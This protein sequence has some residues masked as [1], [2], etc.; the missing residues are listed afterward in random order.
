MKSWCSGYTFSKACETDACFR[1]KWKRAH[2]APSR[3]AQVHEWMSNSGKHGPA[4]LLR[5]SP[6]HPPPSLGILYTACLPMSPSLLLSA[7]SALR[8]FLI[9]LCPMVLWLF[10]ETPP[11]PHLPLREGDP[12]G[13]GPWSHLHFS[14]PGVQEALVELRQ[15]DPE[16]K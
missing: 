16:L 7:S 4:F 15:D 2:V 12:W 6:P 13:Q 8:C 3:V 9:Y 14:A 5:V 1:Y 11:T 10:S